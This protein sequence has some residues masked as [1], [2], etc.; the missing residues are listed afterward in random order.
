MKI[1][2]KSVLAII[3][4][5]IFQFSC[6]AEVFAAN[7]SKDLNVNNIYY[8][9]ILKSQQYISDI[10]STVYEFEHQKTG[11]KIAFVKNDDKY[12]VFSMALA[13]PVKDNT[14][15]NHILE[16]IVGGKGNS[17]AETDDLY[18]AYLRR[19]ADEGSFE[20]CVKSMMNASF[21]SDIDQN[22]M[23][24]EG[25][26]YDIDSPEKDININGVVYNEQ[27]GRS[28]AQDMLDNSIKLT[29]CSDSYKFNPGGNPEDIP[30]L[31]Y[32]N[33]VETY[34]K[35]YTPSNSF[36]FV[37]GDADILKTLQIINDDYFSKFNKTESFS[38]NKNVRTTDIQSYYEDYYSIPEGSSTQNGTYLAMN[39]LMPSDMDDETQTAF[40][41]LMNILTPSLQKAFADHNIGSILWLSDNPFSIIAQGS[42]KSK[43][44]EFK[45]DVTDT[46]KDI[47]NNGFDKEEIE[48]ALHSY[49]I[50]NRKSSAA[51]GRGRQYMKKVF[52]AWSQNKDIKGNLSVI[53]NTKNIKKKYKQD[54][55]YFEELIQKYLLNNTNASL[56]V[57]A[58]KT[59]LEQ[60]KSNKLN[61]TLKKYKQS[62]SSNELNKLVKESNEFNSL[63]SSKKKDKSA[64]LSSVNK[65][66]EEIPTKEDQYNNVKILEHPMYTGGLQYINL[67]F[68]ETK[69][70]QDKLEYLVLLSKIMGQV[71]TSDFNY[72]DLSNKINACTDG[73]DFYSYTP[74]G[75]RCSKNHDQICPKLKISISTQNDNLSDSFLVLQSVILNSSFSDKEHL[76]NLINQIKLDTKNAIN[77][78]ISQ[79]VSDIIDE[80]LSYSSD[81]NKYKNINCMPFYQFICDLDKNFDQKA[82]E[83]IDNLN[84]VKKSVFTKNNLLVSYTGDE[85]EYDNFNSCCSKFLDNLSES[86]LEDVN[87][88]FDYSNKNKA[89]ILP[90][91]SACIVQSADFS[92]LGY[93]CSGKISVLSKVVTSYLKRQLRAKGGAYSVTADTSDTNFWFYSASDPDIKNTIDVFN[94]VPDYLRNFDPD[95]NEMNKYILNTI[96]GID[97]ELD[98]ENKGQSADDMYILGI[99]QDDIQKYREEILSTT[100]E[101]IR[102][103][104]SMIDDILKQN[105]ISAAGNESVLNSNKSIF[106]QIINNN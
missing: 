89:F 74:N 3:F 85:S 82:D 77:N 37:Y 81:S 8:G 57:L 97:I 29:L 47:V 1:N 10:N 41:I 95:E 68:D 33:V 4:M 22:S 27:K 90:S 87:Y 91:E 45:N 73:I 48:S 80:S 67:Y 92:K 32:D 64:D 79:D 69:V 38:S 14:G 86:D 21:M 93:N 43:A 15:V 12:R 60:E 31:T 49:E 13:T 30:K 51:Q 65:K 39:Y 62:L 2:K 106:Q 44:E 40:R 84:S 23:K 5:L 83:I 11:A 28:S 88:K 101:D 78:D 34:K 96:E 103:Y 36:S 53:S 25:W 18:T 26:R 105:N 102:K 59:G 6:C 56:V 42:E 24:R 54:N 7:N 16:H 71:D 99:S 98:P 70:P 17:E 76:K 46:L 9:F 94:S 58:P 63:N 55:K 66:S 100:K 50:D 61:E 104:A 20:E 75:S 52:A 35:Y 19:A 72:Q